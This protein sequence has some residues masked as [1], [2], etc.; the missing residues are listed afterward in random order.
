MVH[1]ICPLIPHIGC[2]PDEHSE[3][4]SSIGISSPDGSTSHM[5]TNHCCHG[6]HNFCP[7]NDLTSRLVS[8]LHC[9]YDI[10]DKILKASMTL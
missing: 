3:I 8:A 2:K 10:A 1:G 4:I 5:T 9:F 6:D 7:L